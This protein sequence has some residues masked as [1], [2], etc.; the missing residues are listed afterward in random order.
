MNFC[1]VFIVAV[2]KHRYKYA[3]EL[4]ALSIGSPDDRVIVILCMEFFISSSKVLI[5]ALL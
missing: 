5:S 1:F 2:I 3:I 4:L